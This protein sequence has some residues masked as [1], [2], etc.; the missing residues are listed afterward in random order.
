MSFAEMGLEL[1]AFYRHGSLGFGFVDQI[2]D[3]FI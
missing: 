2:D 1:V 3:A